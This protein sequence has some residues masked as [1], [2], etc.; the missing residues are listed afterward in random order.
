MRR[1]SR[2]AEQCPQGKRGRPMRPENA[3]ATEKAGGSI[4]E[5]K[6]YLIPGDEEAFDQKQVENSYHDADDDKRYYY[7]QW[8]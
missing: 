2:F 3:Q 1:I 6:I 4:C 5:K 7:L 8:R